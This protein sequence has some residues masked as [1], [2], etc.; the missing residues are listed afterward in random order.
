MLHQFDESTPQIG[1]VDERDA[2]PTSANPRI[3]IYQPC[4]L[5]HQVGE[6]L[7]NVEHGI[8][9]MVQAL[10]LPCEETSDRAIGRERSQQ[11]DERAPDRNHRL[12]NS[13][14]G[15]YLSMDWFDAIAV[16][17]PLDRGLQVVHGDS[18]MVEVV[19]LQGDG[20]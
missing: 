7:F 3:L 11:L 12:L 8:G 16:E 17:I 10:T 2:G 20:G 15:D 19:E 18:D 6:R 14:L 1:R 5:G 4:S 13:L 9:D